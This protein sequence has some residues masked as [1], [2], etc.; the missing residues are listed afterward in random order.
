VTQALFVS[1]FAAGEGR[2]VCLS[3]KNPPPFLDG[4]LDP[5]GGVLSKYFIKSV[6]TYN[7][8]FAFTSLG[9]RIDTGVNKGPDPYVFKINGQV[10]HRIGSLLSDESADPVYAQLYIFDIENEVQNR[11]SIFDRHK[12]SDDG[13]RVDSQIVEGLVRM[14]DE[15][16]ELVKSFRAAR[17][18]LGQNHC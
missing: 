9:A 11:I 2:S 17:D 4:L 3:K 13:N 7:S 1:I 10:H 5:N 16:N 15:S 18:L 8:M 14:F 12:E 6:R